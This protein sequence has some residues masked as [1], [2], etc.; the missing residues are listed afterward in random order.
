MSIIVA[1]CGYPLLWGEDLVNS[2]GIGYGSAVNPLLAVFLVALAVRTVLFFPIARY[3]SDAKRKR[4]VLKRIQKGYEERKKKT[5][6]DEKADQSWL[7]SR[8]QA[9]HVNPLFRVRGYFLVAVQLIMPFLFERIGMLD[10]QYGPAQAILRA[11]LLDRS[12][13]YHWSIVLATVGLIANRVIT[14]LIR[15]DEFVLTE[16][17]LPFFFITV[18]IPLINWNYRLYVVTVVYAAITVYIAMAQLILLSSRIKCKK[19]RSIWK[20]GERAPIQRRTV[21]LS[22]SPS[23]AVAA[24]RQSPEPDSIEHAV[25]RATIVAAVYAKKGY[26]LQ[27]VAFLVSTYLAVAAGEKWFPF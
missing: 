9:E 16:S 3:L 5:P 8:Y 27:V 22:G 17:L 13:V 6:R 15:T 11:N 19:N 14:V 2:L 18:N 24:A 7:M 23:I 25:A 1:I 10:E 21:A 12:G 4:N 26:K 20:A